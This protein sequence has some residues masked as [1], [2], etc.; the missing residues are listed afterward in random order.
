[1]PHNSLLKIEYS[2]NLLWKH[3]ILRDENIKDP[4]YSIVARKSVTFTKNDIDYI[5]GP[6]SCY[7][8]NNN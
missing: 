1:M 2:A 8:K 6:R 3:G 5:I 4:S 7:E